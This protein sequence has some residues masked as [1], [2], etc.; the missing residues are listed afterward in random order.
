MKIVNIINEVVNNFL[1]ENS[2]W[3]H[4]T[5]DVRDINNKG[6]FTP[7]TDT[8]DYI[9]D[10]KKWQETQNA[11]QQARNVGNEDK[12]FKLLDVAGSLRD[13]M[14][15][16]KPI[17]FTD[18]HNVANTYADPHRSFDYQESEPKTIKVNINDNGKTLKIPA[19]GERFRGISVDSI[20]KALNGE[21]VS[22]EEIDKYLAMFPNDISDGKMRTDILA[23]IAQLLGFDIV[24]VLGV[25]DSYHG[26]TTKSTVRMVFDPQRIQIIN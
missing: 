17:F 7:K 26:G 25:L 18:K 3:Y 12:Y 20:R 5:P 2:I 23:V 1:I 9:S 22:N 4:G 16:K 6:S 15:F 21:G 14:T 19:Y 24:D 13:K 11:M 10:P 8:I